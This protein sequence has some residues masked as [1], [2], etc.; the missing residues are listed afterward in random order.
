MPA[1]QGMATAI[2]LA[3]CA[4]VAPMCAAPASAAVACGDLDGLVDYLEAEFGE[5]PMLV[6]GTSV[7]GPTAVPDGVVM[8]LLVNQ[9][10]TTWTLV[11]SGAARAC[12]TASGTAI[13]PAR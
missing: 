13:A 7:I 9:H 6:M 12:I 1:R 4:I 8:I 10:T 11:T 5:V 2:G 3:V